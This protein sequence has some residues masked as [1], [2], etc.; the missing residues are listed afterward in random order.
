VTDEEREKLIDDMAHAIH[1]TEWDADHYD[2]SDQP[3]HIQ[4][5]YRTEARA[6]L[7]IVEKAIEHY[8]DCPVNNAPALPVGKCGCLDKARADIEKLRGALKNWDALIRHQYTGSREAMSDMT[9][10]AQETARLLYGPG[11]WFRP[12]PR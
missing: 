7:A 10:C 6:A 4:N 11:P 2:F 8:S 9:V 3:L 1:S 5:E 12:K